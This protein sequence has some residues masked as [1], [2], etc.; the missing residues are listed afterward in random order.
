MRLLIK[1]ASRSRPTQL[2]SIIHK[3]I[4][5]ANDKSTIVFVISLDKDDETVT[6]AL[7][8]E[9]QHIHPCIKLFVGVSKSKID[10][11][12]RDIPDPQT[13]DILLLASDDMVPEVKGYD[14]I[15]R[16]N[17]KKHYPDTD[18]VLF[19]NDGY[20]GKKLNTLS[21]MGSKYYQ[22]FGYVYYPGYKSFYCDNEFMD[23]A[24]K[25][26]RQTYFD[27]VIIRHRHFINNAVSMDALYER[28]GKYL[29]EDKKLYDQRNPKPK[30]PKMLG[31]LNTHR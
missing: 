5:F 1:L 15:I 20:L 4:D 23:V 6:D 21:I 28:N 13:F 3:Y 24:E 31:F 29:Q 8:A 17:M 18:G 25:L 9:I 7:R 10:A 30:K 26:G 19:F 2:L 12:N 16:Q 11:M 14:N 22:R 27:Q